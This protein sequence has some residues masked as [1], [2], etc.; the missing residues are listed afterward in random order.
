MSRTVLL[1]IG[2]AVAVRLVLASRFGLVADEAYYWAWSERLAAGYFDHPPAIA[3][4]IAGGTTLLGDTEL[5]VRALPVLCGGLAA[6]AVAGLGQG[7]AIAAAL[8]TAPLLALGGVLATP[9][10][11][12]VLAWA[13]GLRFASQ[14]RWPLVGLAAGL[15]ML[16]KYT[17]V[18]LLP[19]LVLGRR[20]AWRTRGPWLAAA[21]AGL[22]YLPNAWWNATHD[23]VSWR[24]QLEH[25]AASSSPGAFLAAQFGLVGPVLFGAML[26]WWAVG[27]RGDDTERLCW[28][29]SLPLLAVAVWAGG[30]ANW[31]APAYLGAVVGL[32]RRAGA[33]GRAF[34]VGVGVSAVL[35]VL[36]LVH[37]HQPLLEFP[38]DPRAR[39]TGGQTL[40][41]SVAAWGIDAVYTS[42]YQEAALIHFYSGVAA[43]ALPE[44]SRPD[45]YDLWPV[46][47]APHALFVR[48]AAGERRTLIE[49]R[50]YERSGPNRVTAFISGT[51]P[52]RPIAVR[53]WQVYELWSAE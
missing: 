12:L 33:L 25:V 8:A 31:A 47:M 29:A 14:D 27:W 53:E 16:A 3:W 18:L 13:L 51:D 11:P 23:L 5:G 43:H 19:L 44:H 22:V 38:G 21:I 39:L 41:D 32:S 26:A 42:R 49:E 40:A 37:L 36:A 34:H 46:E 50:G 28:W 9:D 30:E 1:V 52:L 17:G 35:S 15:A 6:L 4:L 20:G 45:Q 24:F 48:P 10:V 2:A 7:T